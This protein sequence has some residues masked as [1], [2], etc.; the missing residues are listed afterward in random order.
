MNKA[1][2]LQRLGTAA[3][4]ESKSI[5]IQAWRKASQD[6][7]SPETFQTTVTRSAN[8]RH[9]SASKFFRIAFG[10]L[11]NGIDGSNGKE[12]Q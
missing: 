3:Y 4:K 6:S 10:V 1:W 2:T 12:K 11:Y 9:T 8:D 7:D 5:S